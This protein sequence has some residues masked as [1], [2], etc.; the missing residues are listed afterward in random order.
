MKIAVYS[1]LH[2]ERER[3]RSDLKLLDDADLRILAGDVMEADSYYQECV[4]WILSQGD[5]PTVFIAG[6]HEFFGCVWDEQIEIFRSTF[7]GTSVHFLERDALKIGGWTILG[8]TL[9]TDLFLD[10]DPKKSGHYARHAMADYHEIMLNRFTRLMPENS[11]RIHQISL[12]W[13]EGQL[14]KK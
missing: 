11:T 8:C 3:G 9:W 4:D 6:N 13:L 7:E 2:L 10:G 1:D 14:I 5:I 12:D